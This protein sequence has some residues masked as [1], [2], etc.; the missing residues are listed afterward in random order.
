MADLKYAIYKR[1]V[2]PVQVLRCR[3]GTILHWVPFLWDNYGHW[4]Y[5]HLMRT[6]EFQLKTLEREVRNDDVHEF[7]SMR[8][9][10]IQEVIR[11]IQLEREGLPKPAGARCWTEAIPGST[12]RRW[13]SNQEFSEWSLRSHKVEEEA[14]EKLWKL[15]AK[16]GRGWGT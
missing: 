4:D 15:I 7:S 1:F 16:N 8:A 13:R 2:V 12:N 10:E 3:L 9:D 14:W 11:L 6:I 5:E